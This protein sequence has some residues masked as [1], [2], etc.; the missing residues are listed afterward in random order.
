MADSTWFHGSACPPGN[1][2]TIPSR[3]CTSAMASTVAATSSAAR[4]PPTSGSG[5]DGF[6][7]RRD[8]WRDPGRLGHVDDQALARDR[9]E[10]PLEDAQRRA[11]MDDVP[12]EQAVVEANRPGPLVAHADRAPE[13]P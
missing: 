3:S 11:R 12:H 10:G 4:T 6:P 5:T 7:R 8:R 2:G 13:P 9:V 1:Q